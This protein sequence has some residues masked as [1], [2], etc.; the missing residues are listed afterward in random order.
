MGQRTDIPDKSG[1]DRLIM[2][3]E[4]AL[5]ELMAERAAAINRPERLHLDRQIET[6]REMLRGA[7]KL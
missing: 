1:R 7:A 6:F 3:C 5:D 2:L 4:A